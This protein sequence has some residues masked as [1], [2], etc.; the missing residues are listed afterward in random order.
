MKYT[1]STISDIG[2]IKTKNQ[3]SIL[4]K[5]IKTGNGDSIILSIVCDGVGGLD[6]GEIASFTVIHKFNE[7]I[8]DFLIKN[9][10]SLEKVKI[11]WDYLI[12]DL[13]LKIYE[14]GKENSC[15]LG[16]TISAILIY[17][18]NYLISQVGDSRIYK[19]EDKIE[20]LTKD[21]TVGQRELDLGNITYF[22]F[23][24]D[25]RRS[26]LLQAIGTSKSIFPV[27]SYGKIGKYGTILICSDGFSNKLEASEMYEE[28][29]FRNLESKEIMEDRLKS[30]VSK[31]KQRN[32]RDNIS[33]ILLK[34]EE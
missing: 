33:A 22:E 31:V 17:N 27:Y 26:I 13:N 28:L 32:E 34:Y 16:T 7:W 10:F 19:I 6:K 11:D 2:N 29:E 8:S 3:D 5:N 1:V 21:Q 23:K 12:K 9:S 24:E 14:Y 15:T 18:D 25:R 20:K 30:L 4:V